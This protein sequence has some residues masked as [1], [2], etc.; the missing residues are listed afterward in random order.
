MLAHKLV[1]WLISVLV[2]GE[3]IDGAAVAIDSRSVVDHLAPHL[4]TPVRREPLG[5]S[6]LEINAK[7]MQ[8]HDTHDHRRPLV[9]MKLKWTPKN[10]PSPN[11][12]AE[13]TLNV[14][15]ER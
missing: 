7:V 11:K 3:K 5:K 15:A 8:A 4:E 1:V 9:V 10:T 13:C 6:D 2:V 14:H 12:H